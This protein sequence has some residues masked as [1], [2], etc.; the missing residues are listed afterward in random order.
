MSAVEEARAKVEEELGRYNDFRHIIN[1]GG[2]D[3]GDG[4]RQ[5]EMSELMPK[6]VPLVKAQHE[7][8]VA[9]LLAL[10]SLEDR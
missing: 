3:N 5:I 2:G 1:T 6:L 4:T 7:A 9:L 10:E 8:I